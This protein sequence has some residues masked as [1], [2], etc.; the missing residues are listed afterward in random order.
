MQS[1]HKALKI[2]L[3]SVLLSS[4]EMTGDIIKSIAYL[5]GLVLGCCVELLR[6]MRSSQC[7]SSFTFTR[8]EVSPNKRWNSPRTTSD[9]EHKHSD[10]LETLGYCVLH[11]S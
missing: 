10:R 11:Q 7:D 9:T 5:F 1:I 6:V 2:M 4:S 8:M 3:C